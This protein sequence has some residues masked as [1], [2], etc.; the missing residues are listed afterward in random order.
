[1]KRS[2]VLV[3][4]AGGLGCPVLQYI[5]SAGVGTIGILDDDKVSRS[6]LQRQVLFTDRDL[7]FLKAEVAADRLRAM[8]GDIRCHAYPVRLDGE[9]AADFLSEYDLIVDGSDNFATRYVINDACVLEGKPWVFGALHSFQGQVSVFN[10]EGGPTYRCLFPQPPESGEAPTCA[11]NGVLGVLPGIIGALQAAEVIKVLTGIGT[12]LSGKLL[13]FDALE[14]SQQII[15]FER[16]PVEAE[17]PLRGPSESPNTARN[18]EVEEIEMGRGEIEAG[19]AKESFQVIDVRD[20]GERVLGEIEGAVSIPLARL[21]EE[22]RGLAWADL[23]LDPKKP[24]LVF[25]SGGLRS[26]RGAHL[27]RS[28]FG[29]REVKVLV[30]DE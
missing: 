24:T 14:M 20:L 23:A 16:D 28:E 22:K 6:N 3:V 25:C 10:W 8:N 15:R 2:R 13:L 5:A 30:W 9:N 7:G 4:G 19:I 29:F 11:E 17:V 12:P 27:L 18:G 1:L 26:V 21:E